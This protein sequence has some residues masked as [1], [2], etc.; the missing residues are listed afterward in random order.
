LDMDTPIHLHWTQH[1]MTT[2]CD[3]DNELINEPWSTSSDVDK[4][5][6]IKVYV[7]ITCTFE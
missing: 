4:H 7:S 3:I 5:F 6:I 1:L 2:R